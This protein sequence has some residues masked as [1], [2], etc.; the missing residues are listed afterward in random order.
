MSMLRAFLLCC[1]V[2][3]M[4]QMLIR[5]RKFDIRIWVLVVDEGDVYVYL[6]G[7]IRTSSEAFSLDRYAQCTDRFAWTDWLDV[8]YVVCW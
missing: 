7:Y 8:R 1:L 6:P 3:R 2:V 4:E 5:S